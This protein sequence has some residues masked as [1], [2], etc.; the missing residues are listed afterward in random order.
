MAEK[1]YTRGEGITPIQ[2]M[3]TRQ[4]RKYIRERAE[5]AQA[6]LDT[7][8][9]LEDTS[10]A[11]QE[12]LKYVESFGSVR[13]GAIKKD[14]SRMLK[15]EMAMYAYALRDL[16]MLDT[17]SKYAR[18]S[19][20]KQNKDRYTSFVKKM[21]S[22]KNLSDESRAHW[23]EYLTDKGNVRKAGYAEYK[24]YINFIKS[25]D[26]TIATYGY[27]TVQ[28]KYYAEE[29]QHRQELVSQVLYNTYMDHKGEGL[30]PGE[31][32]DLV[33]AELN[34]YDA[35]G[36]LKPEEVPAPQ[37][38]NVIPFETKRETKRQAKK[39]PK[40]AR[41]KVPINK[42]LKKAKK[43]FK[44]GLKK[45]KKPTASKGKNTVKTQRRG[46]MKGGTVREKQGTKK[47]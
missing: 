20:Y 33:D 45:S 10:E 16:N 28:D 11:F 12:Q 14:T 24:E 44:K 18:D 27:E 6:R 42:T 23:K 17:E 21:A 15:D 47:L 13:G 40:K 22:D 46:K 34:K 38:D 35:F 32:L 30:D 5:E 1:D 9:D 29:N 19:E 36:N 37:E 25:I 39:A 43:N 41:K 7:L 8:A 3:T 2:E 4:L 31:L 26:E